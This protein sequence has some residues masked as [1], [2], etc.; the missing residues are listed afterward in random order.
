MI[1]NTSVERQYSFY[2]PLQ[3]RLDFGSIHHVS[4]LHSKHNSGIVFSQI[5]LENWNELSAKQY[6]EAIQFA[7][8]A[9]N[10]PDTYMAVNGVA[11]F[12][13]RSYLTVNQLTCNFVDA[14]CYTVGITQEQ[15]I[16]RAMQI[17]SDSGLSAPTRIFNSGRGLYLL[18]EYEKPV[19]VGSKSDKSAGIKAAWGI[20]QEKLIELFSPIGAD[21]SLQGCCKSPETGR[22]SKQQVTEQG[23]SL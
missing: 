15:A 17:C 2:K 6:N 13:N 11:P 16:N 7:R 10:Q 14:D 8:D 23:D 12:R 18:W 19:Y 22:H 9:A 5:T 21:V 4:A 1:T 3:Q 20:T